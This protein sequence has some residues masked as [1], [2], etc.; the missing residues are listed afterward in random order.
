LTWDRAQ[1]EEIIDRSPTLN[2]NALRITA[3]RL[4]SAEE[5]ARELATER[6]AQRLSRTLFRLLG[7]VGRPSD[8]SVFVS[9]T[10]EEL[11]QMTGTTLF[12]VSRIFSA[13]E[14]EGVIRPRREGVLIDDSARL[15]SIAESQPLTRRQSTS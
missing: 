9:L 13:W 6:V 10:R 5:H 3:Q 11:A 4:R 2:R 12:T 1:L 15:V 8:G 7:Q 14:T